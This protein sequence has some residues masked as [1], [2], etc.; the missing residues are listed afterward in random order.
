MLKMGEAPQVPMILIQ[1]VMR[2]ESLQAENESAARLSHVAKRTDTKA[3]VSFRV[4][5]LVIIQ[6][7]DKGDV[8]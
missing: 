7:Q 4:K 2:A 5:S 1:Y 8:S 3:F 6:I